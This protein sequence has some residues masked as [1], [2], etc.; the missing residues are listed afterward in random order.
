MREEN[1]E[2]EEKEHAILNS[3]PV[4]TFEHLMKH[5]NIHG[6]GYKRQSH[7]LY[8][9][10]LLLYYTVHDHCIINIINICIMLRLDHT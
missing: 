10:K 2:V 7:L 4:D 6:D 9:I 8:Y 1:V 3:D 5:L